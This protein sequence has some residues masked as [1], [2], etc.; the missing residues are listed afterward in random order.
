MSPEEQ[1]SGRRDK[2]PRNPP[3]AVGTQSFGPGGSSP[4]FVR[5]PVY[6]TGSVGIGKST[7]TFNLAAAW[8][9]SK[10]RKVILVPIGARDE[11]VVPPRE[12]YKRLEYST[13]F[14]EN[15][16]SLFQIQSMLRE[17]RK[18]GVISCERLCALASAHIDFQKW[19]VGL[20]PLGDASAD[21]LPIARVVTMLD[22]LSTSYD[23]FVELDSSYSQRDFCLRNSNLVFWITRNDVEDA[24]RICAVINTW[25]SIYPD[26]PAVGVV[27]N[28]IRKDEKVHE[29][30]EDILG[31]KI[32]GRIIREDSLEQVE[33]QPVV[34]SDTSLCERAFQPLLFCLAKREVG[35]GV[36]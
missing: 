9:K 6:I 23:T 25:P 29:G 8:A 7:V 21:E 15:L 10:G 28:A 26:T 20:L 34:L 24:R 13:L 33:R 22:F 11:K 31:A 19:G 18:D 32:L 16:T 27:L 3:T 12:P 1:P 14:G 17:E 35:F 4:V 2:P 36:R 5:R 30:L